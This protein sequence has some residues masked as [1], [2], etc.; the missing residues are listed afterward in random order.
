MTL[1]Q[2]GNSDLNITRIGIGTWAI[3]GGKWEF[4]WGPQNDDDSIEAIHAG[5]IGD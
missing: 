5:W 3:G 1:R 2:L 4:G